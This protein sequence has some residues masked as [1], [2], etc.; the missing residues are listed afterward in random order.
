MLSA[1]FHARHSKDNA[2]HGK[3]GDLRYRGN[4]FDFVGLLSVRCAADES[5]V[6]AWQRMRL[7]VALRRSVCENDQEK[8]SFG[9]LSTFLAAMVFKGLLARILDGPRS[10]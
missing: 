6:P 9:V 2:V 4:I 10:E 1:V 8:G 5:T 7:F 3:R